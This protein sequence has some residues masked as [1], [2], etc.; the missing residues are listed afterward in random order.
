MNVNCREWRFSCEF[1]AHRNHSRYP[2]KDNIK[3]RNQNRGRI[4][5]FEV[6]S[7]LI[8]PSHGRKRPQSRRKPRIKHVSFLCEFGRVGTFFC[9]DHFA[10]FVVVISRN[11]MSPP[12]LSGN[13]PVTDVFHPA[14]VVFSPSFGYKFYFAFVDGF[15]CAFCERFHLNEP[16]FRKQ[17]LNCRMAALAFADIVFM[18]GNFY[19]IVVI[20]EHCDC[21]FACF[22]AV[23]PVELLRNFRAGFHFALAVDYPDGF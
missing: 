16:L 3:S 2:E 6:L 11:L 13:A 22:V 7:V 12:Q 15:D 10:G 9:N 5:F 19:Q 8:R 4:E 17:R 18:V 14:E 20:T 23:E 1:V 21:F